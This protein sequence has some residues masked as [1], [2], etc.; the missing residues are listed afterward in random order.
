MEDEPSISKEITKSTDFYIG[1]LLAVCSSLF[2]GTSFI[3]KKISLTRLSR[4]GALRAGA[5]GFGYLKDW[6][7]WLGISAMGFGEILNFAAYGFAPA[8]VVTPLGALSV[9][10]SAILASKFLNEKL[11]IV[12]KLGCLLCILGSTMIILHAPKEEPL[13]NFNLF[14]SKLQEPA[15]AHYMICMV[16]LCSAILCCLGPRFGSRYVCVYITLCSAIGGITVMAC[17][18]IGLALKSYS[19]TSLLSYPTFWLLSTIILIMAVCICVQITYLNRTLDLFNASIVT[20]TYYVFFTGFVI[21][22]SIVL[23][24]E[25]ELMTAGDMAGALCGFFVTV[26]AVFVLSTSKDGHQQTR[27]LGV[28]TYFAVKS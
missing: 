1:I 27:H 26:V 10:V 12:G 19:V 25:W 22:E 20:P 18:A 3:I 11:T 5:G 28:N 16:V 9:L 17:K 15:F 21:A 14:L 4:I 7:W 24:R 23:F 6:F 8:S 2:I 13:E